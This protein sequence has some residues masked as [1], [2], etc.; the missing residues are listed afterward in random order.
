MSFEEFMKVDTINKLDDI[1]MKLR[2]IGV[3]DI[4]IVLEI[5]Y[6]YNRQI[7]YIAQVSLSSCY[8]LANILVLKRVILVL[9]ARLKHSSNR[10]TVLNRWSNVQEAVLFLNGME[11][12]Q[13]KKVVHQQLISMCNLA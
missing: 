9:S 3:D 7:F 13:Q 4:A 2:N 1:V 12:D 8:K 5:F 10:V 11:K 6:S